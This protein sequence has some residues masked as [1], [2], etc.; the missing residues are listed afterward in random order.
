MSYPVIGWHDDGLRPSLQLE[1]L[2]QLLLAR[3][4]LS[5]CHGVG[6]V[7]IQS[8]NQSKKELWLE[9]R[10]FS[11][12]LV[13]MPLLLTMRYRPKLKPTPNPS[14]T[15]C[16]P[17]SALCLQNA[18]EKDPAESPP[19][20]SPLL[21]LSPRRVPPPLPSSSLS[22]EAQA[23][24]RSVPRGSRSGRTLVA[25]NTVFCASRLTRCFVLVCFCLC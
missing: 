13:L 20:P 7:Q 24:R 19:S 21:L 4:H 9:N 1:L 14:P 25:R 6:P 18:V 10:A 23:P 16:P 17:P 5:L 22:L 12:F 8:I 3:R 2:Y 15:W 11:L